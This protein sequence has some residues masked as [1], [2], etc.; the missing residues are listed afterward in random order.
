MDWLY[1][2]PRIQYT[3][4]IV[5][6]RIRV[7]IMCVALYAESRITCVALLLAALFYSV[8]WYV[9]MYP[10]RKA[11]AMPVSNP[12]I[13]PYA[14]INNLCN[15][16]NDLHLLSTAGLSATERVEYMLCKLS[17]DGC[18]HCEDAGK[19]WRVGFT[20]CYIIE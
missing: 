3:S 17:S 1:L 12:I 7:S 14:F 8:L 4:Y 19:L 20:Y 16:S 2:A 5:T 11:Y 18:I 10:F 9:C 13:Q 6:Q 15:M